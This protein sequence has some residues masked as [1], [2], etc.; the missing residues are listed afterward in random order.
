[1]SSNTKSLRQYLQG[2]L[3]D[4]SD[5]CCMQPLVTATTLTSLVVQLA[6]LREEGAVLIPEVFLCDDLNETLKPL[7]DREVVYIGTANAVDSAIAE[8]IKRC[9][10]LAINGW[11]VFIA[12]SGPSYEYGLFRGSL[13]PISISLYD[14]LFSVPM[15]E[16][17]VVRMF[18]TAT[19]CVELCNHR[20]TTHSILLNDKP[21]SAPLPT[22]YSKELLE[23]ICKDIKD[24]FRDPTKTYIGKTLNKALAAC[25]G[26]IIAVVGRKIPSFLKD[27]VSLKV[28][29]DF[30]EA[31]LAKTNSTSDNSAE[32]R[33][34]ANSSLV[35]GMISSDGIT[36]FTTTG[37]LIAYNC[38]VHS[39]T[40]NDGNPIVG[41]ART[42][43]YEALKRRIGKGIVAVFLQ[44]QDGWTKF[45]KDEK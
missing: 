23:E 31:V 16:L 33:L 22:A 7:P 8:A 34:I 38:F 21:E 10:P 26:T 41:G 3:S 17:K 29:L 30:Q 13:N 39:P 2:A 20:G 27:G 12:K 43:A 14:T 9:G 6:N 1:M 42:R 19:G 4:F 15:E 37:K 45:A 32:H 28:P 40:Q 36:V 5:S 11:C 18:R 24:P 35:Q 44:S 25:H